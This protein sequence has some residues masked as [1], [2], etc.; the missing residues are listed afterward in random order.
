MNILLL[1][2]TGYLGGNIVHRLAQ[3][4]HKQVCV[5]RGSSDTSRIEGTQNV[6]FVS[7]DLSEIEVVFKYSHIDWVVNS[8]C[9]YKTNNTLYGD[10]LVSNILFPLGVLNLAVKYNIKNFITIGT[11]LPED[12]NLYSFTKHKY[13]EFGKFMSHT[14]DINFADLKLEMFYGGLFEPENR[15][16]S[17]CVTKL[18]NNEPI[19]LTEGKQRRDLLQVE[20]VVE[21]ISKLIQSQYLNHYMSQNSGVRPR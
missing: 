1:G 15:F 21:I 7:S 12:I 11:S 9:T 2:A 10:M 18:R 4:G 13:G 16:I 3:D 19:T 5:V 20:D 17:S 14:D 6:S 8:V